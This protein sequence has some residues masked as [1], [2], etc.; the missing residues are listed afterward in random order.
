[1]ARLQVLKLLGGLI[2]VFALFHWIATVLGSDRGQA[3]IVVG[4]IIAAAT[5]AFEAALFK[6]P[7]IEAARFVGLGRPAARG[8]AIA[9]AI[10]LLLFLT[11]PAFGAAT[12]S[13]FSFYP[14]WLWL[15][16]GIFFQAG[17]AE[18]TL[19]RG[20][21]FGH[22]RER[23]DY[24]KAAS[25]SAIPFVLVHLII[26]YSNPW[27][28]AAASVLLAVITSFPLSRLFEI[29]GNTIWPPATVHFAIQSGVKLFIPEGESAGLYPLY[30]IAA[31]AVMPWIVFL[32][33]A[34][35]G[36]DM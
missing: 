31:C 20:Y 23:H 36:K 19:F 9:L 30:W 12:S 6:K 22:F 5:V 24:W 26:F 7:V 14:G 15:V 28:I 2:V 33:P 35:P 3:G 17:I 13:A 21:L 4:L 1:M 16:P 34:S 32:F 8:L 25:L 10:S 27:P 18:E 11:I 29:G